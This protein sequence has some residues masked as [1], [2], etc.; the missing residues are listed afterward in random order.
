MGRR[1]RKVPKSLTYYLN[2][3][4]PSL[5][6]W[7][8]VPF[9][10]VK[11]WNESNYRFLRKIHSSFLGTFGFSYSF[12]YK[13]SIIFKKLEQRCYLT[14]QCNSISFR[15]KIGKFFSSLKGLLQLSV[16]KKKNFFSLWGITCQITTSLQ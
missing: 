16:K 7:I 8:Q 12:F 3:P 5:L 10:S 1:V 2:G 6:S 11:F 13:L 15:V 14:L 4:C 9:F